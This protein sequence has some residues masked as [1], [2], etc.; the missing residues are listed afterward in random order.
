MGGKDQFIDTLKYVDSVLQQATGPFFLG[1]EFTLVDVQFAPFLERMV[2]S[3]LYYKGFVIRV[4][5]SE[6]ANAEYPGINA[7]FDAM[8]ELPAYQLTK[9]DYYTHAWDLPPQLGGCRSEQGGKPYED[10]INGVRSLDSKQGSWELPLQ[11][12]NGGVEPDWSFIPGGES[13]ARREAVE[14]ISSNHDAI[15]KF[16][17]RGAGSKGFPGFGAPLADPNAVPNEALQSSVDMCLRTVCSAL[18]AEDVDGYDADMNNIAKVIARNGGKEYAGGVVASLSY[19]RDRVGVP[20]D[21]R[22]PA[23]RQLRAHL[24]WSIGK[25]L[26]AAE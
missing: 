4:P 7:W 19:L 18:L 9:S 16:A 2:A 21:M 11:P 14:R 26:D 15:V 17:C 6:K 25:I 13:A 20:R 3:L 1:K 23:A 5:S 24:N 8:E 22:L 10:A 12:D